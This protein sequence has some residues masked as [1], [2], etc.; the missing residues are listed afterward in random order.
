MIR[1]SAKISRIAFRECCYAL[2]PLA[3]GL[4]RLCG[5]RFDCVDFKQGELKED[6][7][8]RQFMQYLD[9]LG[10]EK[11]PMA[12]NFNNEVL[13]VRKRFKSGTQFHIRVFKDRTVNGHY[14]YS[15][16]YAPVWHWY[17]RMLEPRREEFRRIL[18]NF[19]IFK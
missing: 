5:F 8:F 16:E 18:G 1:R 12:W 10:F 7:T 15:P 17:Q 2:F 3:R 11:N 19:L 9:A 6:I 14:E 13:N 4:Y